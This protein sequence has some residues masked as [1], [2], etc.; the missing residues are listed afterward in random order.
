MV[1]SACGLRG[2]EPT[3]VLVQRDTESEGYKVR[4][5][6]VRCCFLHVGDYV[7]C[8]TERWSCNTLQL[9]DKQQQ[10][11]EGS[12][13]Q[14]VDLQN[15]TFQTVSSQL[16]TRT[17]QISQEFAARDYISA[18]QAGVGATTKLALTQLDQRLSIQQ[19]TKSEWLAEL[20]SFLEEIHQELD[21][22]KNWFDKIASHRLGMVWQW[23]WTCSGLCLL[24]MLLAVVMKSITDSGSVRSEV[25]VYA[26]SGKDRLAESLRTRLYLTDCLVHFD[27]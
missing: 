7:C 6:L 16:T 1:R 9:K 25:R 17:S 8:W 14:M 13:R 26:K 27:D 24:I 19:Q 3:R 2:K 20:D 12:P 21:T 11:A 4:G 23:S 10:L 18:I 15:G 22:E 5:M